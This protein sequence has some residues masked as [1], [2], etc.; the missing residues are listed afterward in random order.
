MSVH[1]LSSWI[2][3]ITVTDSNRQAFEKDMQK[4]WFQVFIF[5]FNEWN[6]GKTIRKS[7][8]NCV[9]PFEP[10]SSDSIVGNGVKPI[11][12]ILSKICI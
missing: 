8:D 9:K 7:I 12:T 11:Q 5:T 10:G 2:T 6:I 4:K 3:S 1:S